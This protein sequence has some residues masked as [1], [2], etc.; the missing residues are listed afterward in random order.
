MINLTTW[1]QVFESWRKREADNPGWIKTATKIKGWPDWESWRSFTATQF[2]ADKLKWA[3][4]KV[5]EPLEEIPKMLVGPYA[6]WQSA[7]PGKNTFSFRDLLEIPESYDKFSNHKT[8]LSIMNNFPFDTEF[9]GLLREDNQKIVCIEGHHRAVAVT[10]AKKLN[11]NIDLSQAK[12]TIALAY[13]PE[14]SVYL[15]DE[16]LRR[17]SSKNPVE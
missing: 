4:Y 9:I 10:L 17:G 11:K 6:G 15:L 16:T 5:D 3:I 14:K 13:L 7:L 1:E 8:V 12:I 2:G